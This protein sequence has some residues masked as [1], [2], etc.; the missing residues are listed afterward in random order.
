MSLFSFAQE[1]Y[2][3]KVPG[4]KEYVMYLHSYDWGAAVNLLVCDAAVTLNPDSI[5][6]EDFKVERVIVNE[7]QTDSARGMAYS[8]K[9]EEVYPS[10]KY[11]NPV[12]NASRYIAIKLSVHYEDEECDFYTGRILKGRCKYYLYRITNKNLKLSITQLSGI[13]SPAADFTIQMITKDGLTIKYASWNPPE[14]KTDTPLIIWFHGIAE[15]GDNPYMPLLGLKSTALISENIQK[16]FPE[17]ACVLIPQCPTGWLETIDTD[18]FGMRVWAPVDIGGT[19]DRKL[20]SARKFVTGLNFMDSDVRSGKYQA[21]EMEKNED[22]DK[23]P[24]AA[25]SY[26]TQVVKAMIDSYIARNPWIDTSRIYVGG[27]S[28]GGYMTMNMLIQYPDFFAAAFP[29]CEAYPDVKITD[30]QIEKL[31]KIPLWFTHAENDE[32]IKIANHD[33]PTYERLK[34]AGAKDLHYSLFPN[35]IDSEGVEID[36]HSSWSYVLNNQ[37]QEGDLTLFEWLSRQ[38][39]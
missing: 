31:A 34:Q 9:I 12:K 22:P 2:K 23:K 20:D 26:Y 27:C 7:D 30:A 13:V 39:K 28:A 25:V 33:G 18:V 37:C 6:T 5:K 29:V 32:T 21:P 16:Y 35:V 15:G 17:G 1:F 14:E 24:Y 10:D 38:K 3:E 36:G 11:G 4:Q 8:R 19:V